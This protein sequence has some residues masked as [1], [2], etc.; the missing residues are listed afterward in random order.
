MKDKAFASLAELLY[1]TMDQIQREED[2]D[3]ALTLMILS[4]TYFTDQKN[5]EGIH[6]K[7]F[8]QVALQKHPYWQ[9]VGLWDK[10]IKGAILDELGPQKFE[11][12]EDRKMREQNVVFGKLGTFSHN[13][14][15]FGI[16]KQ[17][18]ETMIFGFAQDRQLPAP[19]I[20]ALKQTINVTAEQLQRAAPPSK[21]LFLWM[22]DI[23]P[24]IEAKEEIMKITSPAHVDI[25]KSKNTATEE[26]KKVGQEIP[27]PTEGKM[28]E[29]KEEIAKK[30]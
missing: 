17:V 1:L 10:A 9:N 27:K 5:A 19:F 4:Q 18:V 22:S 29:T 7:I 16:P 26:S 3:S 15:Q 14:L 20:E 12:E 13:M 11:S 28:S 23:A 25:D 6:E 2:I 30:E 21:D 8:L 24:A